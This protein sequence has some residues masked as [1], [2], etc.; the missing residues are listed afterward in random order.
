[1]DE[2]KSKRTGIIVRGMLSALLLVYLVFA[3]FISDHL[4]ANEKVGKVEITV[5]DNGSRQFVNTRNI[6]NELGSLPTDSDFVKDVNL[7]EIERTLK[8]FVNIEDASVNKTIGG[9][10]RIRVVPMVPVARVF[11]AGGYS[12]Y[13]NAEGKKLKANASYHVDVPIV[14]GCIDDSVVSAVDLLPVMNFVAGDS[15]W[16][17]LTSAF[18][19]EKNHDLLLIPMIKGHVVNLGDYRDKNTADKFRR[20]ATFYREV[21]PKKGWQFYDTI[22][23]K[24]DGQV[25]ATRAKK[26]APV[27]ELLY[28]LEDT[29][30]VDL[31]N[32]DTQPDNKNN[33]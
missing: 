13:I 7:S 15:L 30:E 24:F 10:I 2:H 25:V 1:M 17:S 32:T 23:V 28:E 31:D 19:V 11:D 29:E 12:Y 18:K 4:Y 21:M 3:F 16:N 26:R 5:V 14:S 33:T 27:P 8:Q 9:N 6:L 20:L 22:S